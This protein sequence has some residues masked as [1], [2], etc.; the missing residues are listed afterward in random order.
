M[1]N[2]LYIFW[3]KFSRC[4]KID[5][6]SCCLDTFETCNY[7]VLPARFSIGGGKRRT[8]NSMRFRHC[9][10]VIPRDRTYL[11]MPCAWSGSIKAREDVLKGPGHVPFYERLNSNEKRT[12]TVSYVA[13]ASCLIG[14]GK[15]RCNFVVATLIAVVLP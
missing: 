14:F 12:V 7:S 1:Q 6:W 3:R 9:R 4:Y 2:E 10:N 5:V 15:E 8:A 13:F 11:Q